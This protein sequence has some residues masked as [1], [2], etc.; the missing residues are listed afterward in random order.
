M[1]HWLHQSSPC[2]WPVSQELPWDDVRRGTG[3]ERSLK[4]L[5]SIPKIPRFIILAAELTLMW[6]EME[7]RIMST[8]Q[9]ALKVLSVDLQKRKEFS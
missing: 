3:T 6:L 7:P 2:V 1:G 5:V 8:K 4:L 9:M